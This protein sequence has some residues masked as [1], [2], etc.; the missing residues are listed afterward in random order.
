MAAYAGIFGSD[1]LLDE[2]VPDYQLLSVFA[3]ALDDVAGLALSAF[4]ARNPDYARGSDL[5]ALAPLYGLSRLSGEPD[6]A[7]RLR[8]REVLRARRCVP[9][10]DLRDALRAVP[11]VSDVSVLAN[12]TASTDDRGIPPGSLACV[13]YG[14]RVNDVAQVLFDLKAP[15]VKLFGSAS[16]TALDSEG[17][18]HP[19]AFS[20]PDSWLLTVAIRLRPLEGYDPDV[21]PLIRSAVVDFVQSGGIGRPVVVSQLYAVCYGAVPAA[22]RGS[23]MITDILTS[24][25]RGS[26]SDVY[27]CAWNE[28]LT[29]RADTVTITEVSS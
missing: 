13:V 27:P 26:H 9:L 4:N 24:T 17:R 16:G 21:Q 2:S 29:A 15:G 7:L 14:G 19:V 20:R 5:D 23:F 28:R 6:A 22:R 25:S 11:Y 18:S 10:T 12:E 8:I 1:M 3:K